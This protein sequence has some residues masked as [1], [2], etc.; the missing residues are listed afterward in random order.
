[1][2][3]CDRVVDA[4]GSERALDGAARSGIE[5][6]AASYAKE[7]LRVLAVARR[8][9]DPDRPLP[10][11]REEAES[12][13]AFLGLA[14]MF[15]PPGRRSRPPSRAAAQRA[16]GSSSSPATRGSP[17]RRSHAASASRRTRS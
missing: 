17:P 3:R 8:P 4:D 5:G 10:E 12:G 6:R 15:D 1:M 16:S 14:A 7:G 2:A 11:G 13:L 9:L